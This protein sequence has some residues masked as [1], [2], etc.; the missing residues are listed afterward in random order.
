[1]SITSL[2]ESEAIRRAVEPA[3][4]RARGPLTRWLFSHLTGSTGASRPAVVAVTDAGRDEDVQLALYCCYELHYRGFDGVDPD[5]EWDPEVLALRQALE[6]C[7]LDDIRASIE[8]P[9]RVSPGEAEAELLRMAS[10]G[11]GPS[12]SGVIQGTPSLER[13]RELFIHRSAYQLKEADPHT[14]AIPRLHGEA[15]AATVEIQA[16][17]YGAGVTAAMHAELFAETM[18]AVDLDPGYGGYLGV[19]PGV[20]LATTNLISLLGLHR[21]W[22]GAL[23]GHLALFEMTSVGP[24]GRYAAALER[25]GVGPEGRRFYDV[26]VEADEEHQ[27]IALERMVR[28]LLREEPDLAADVVFGAAALTEVERRFAARLLDA[29][30]AGRCSLLPGPRLQRVDSLSA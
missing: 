3:L 5:M 24:M 11:D 18:R 1:M 4:P 15:K 2:D 7:F 20:T 13:V 23:L 26:H 21:R 14:W 6:S 16:D 27:H 29:W 17:E 25:L 10:G 30:N 9:S 22:R 8:P 19:I 12:L 28:G